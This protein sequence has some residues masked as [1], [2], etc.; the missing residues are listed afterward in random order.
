MAPGSWR[1]TNLRPCKT[2]FW[3]HVIEESIDSE[4]RGLVI[5]VVYS[6]T[7]VL[8]KTG[9]KRFDLSA[10]K[11]EDDGNHLKEVLLKEMLPF[12]GLNGQSFHTI[13]SKVDLKY[14]C[15]SQLNCNDLPSLNDRPI[16]WRRDSF[17]GS[18]V[19]DIASA[20]CSPKC[21]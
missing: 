9:D 3:N 18:N 6:T 1:E 19:K 10:R 8:V 7:Q 15:R 14:R 12:I 2:S 16:H 13:V 17:I 5:C 20:L 11:Q 4:S 21:S